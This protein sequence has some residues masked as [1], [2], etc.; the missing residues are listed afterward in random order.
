MLIIVVWCIFSH[1]LHLSSLMLLLLIHRCWSYYKN[2]LSLNDIFLRVSCAFLFW[3]FWSR[4]LVIYASNNHHYVESFCTFPVS[5]YFDARDRLI[6][7]ISLC[8]RWLLWLCMMI[9]WFHIVMCWKMENAEFQGK[10]LISQFLAWHSPKAKEKFLPVLSACPSNL[11]GKFMT[12]ICCIEFG[13]VFSYV[14][15]NIVK[16]K[17]EW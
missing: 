1:V 3:L 2:W 4:C 5:F 12:V 9:Y 8:N 17:W 16:N 10:G 7:L 15:T 14:I 13:H 11:V 6:L